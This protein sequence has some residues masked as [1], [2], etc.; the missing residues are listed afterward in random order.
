MP[1]F[2]IHC[3][4]F[5]EFKASDRRL[6]LLKPKAA[7]FSPTFFFLTTVICKCQVALSASH[8]NRGTQK[9]VSF[10]QLSPFPFP[11]LLSFFLF[12]VTG[13]RFFFSAS[14]SSS[15]LLLA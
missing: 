2:I 6:S 11:S 15:L 9:S 12:T 10:L 8:F 14:H 13:T 3:D 1:W 5:L 7:H 4:L